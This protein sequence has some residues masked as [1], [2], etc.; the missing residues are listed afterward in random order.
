MLSKFFQNVQLSS[1]QTILPA[2]K[3]YKLWAKYNNYLKAL[4]SKSSRTS[5][6]YRGLQNFKKGFIWECISRIFSS[7]YSDRFHGKAQ[8][9]ESKEIQETSNRGTPKL[10]VFPTQVST[11][12]KVHMQEHTAESAKETIRVL[13]ATV[14]CFSQTQPPWTLSFTI[15][16]KPSH[17][18]HQCPPAKVAHNRRSIPEPRYLKIQ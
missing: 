17:V 1:Y 6:F 12:P 14:C 10:C 15:K 2:D 9:L 3:N 11:K 13:A 5:R 8:P 16:I 18:C 4:E 7:F